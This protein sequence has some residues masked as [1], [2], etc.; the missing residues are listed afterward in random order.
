MNYE[1]NT[2]GVIGTGGEYDGYLMHIPD[3]QWTTDHGVVQD[4][5][6]V[7]EWTENGLLTDKFMNWLHTSKIIDRLASVHIIYPH[8]HNPE[9]NVPRREQKIG[10]KRVCYEVEALSPTVKR[11]LVLCGSD[12]LNKVIVPQLD[13]AMDHAHGMI[14]DVKLVT[15]TVQ[16]V[17]T[18]IEIPEHIKQYFHRDVWRFKNLVKPPAPLKHIEPN[19]TEI[20]NADKIVIDLETTGFNSYC[21]KVTTLGIQWSKYNRSLITENVYESIDKLCNFNK[22][23][24]FF[25]NAQF[26]LA[27]LGDKFRKSVVGRTHCTMLRARATGELVANL[28]HLGTLYTDSPGNY[29]WINPDEEFSF[30]DPK[31]VCEDLDV[32]WKLSEY[33]SKYDALP[34]VQLFEKCAVMAADQTYNGSMIDQEKLKT[35]ESDL[36][37]EVQKQEQALTEKYGVNPNSN[38]ELVDALI[39]KGYKLTKKTKSGKKMALDEEVLEN[40]GLADILEYRKTSKLHG[41]FLKKLNRLMRDNGTLPHQQSLLAARSGRSTMSEDN[42]Q[43]WPKEGPVK[44]LLVSRFPGGYIA[45][46]DLQG[47]ELNAVAYLANSKKFA[48]IL[49]TKDAHSINAAKAFDIPIEQVRKPVERHVTKTTTF[50]IIYGGFPRTDQEKRVHEFLK[51]EYPEIFRLLDGFGKESMDNKRIADELYGKVNNLLDIFVYRG[52]WG[53]KRAGLNS[54]IQGLSSH[55]AFEITYYIWRHL[56]NLRSLCL[57]GVHDSVVIDI[58]PDELDTVIDIVKDAFKNIWN[59]P[60]A[61]L[62]IF[63][64]LPLRGD[65]IIGTSWG[66]CEESNEEYK[67]NLPRTIKV[68]SHEV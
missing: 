57:F 1:A 4:L 64:M 67:L 9:K 62:P 32:T 41:T 22:P 56:I 28:K 24:F 23:D 40:L 25:H 60:L 47:A 14:F 61:R 42:L 68:S 31:Y 13:K 38:D 35:I 19:W 10:W 3:D 52:K 7:F 11:V 51:S 63:K 2:C 66:N 21:D 33:F 58:H 29:A 5:A 16:L 65:L 18:F 20:A 39:E 17:P 44:P 12:M 36:G 45:N 6:I 46:V 54:P 49:A 26:D 53:V 27:F 48:R 55:I 15:K 37:I 43:Q 34:V 8:K 30:D 50:K 59:T